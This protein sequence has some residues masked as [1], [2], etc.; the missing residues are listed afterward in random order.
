M[1]NIIQYSYYLGIH[2]DRGLSEFPDSPRQ[3][4]IARI[5]TISHLCL[6]S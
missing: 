1:L 4:G 2:R 6:P 5:I 3:C